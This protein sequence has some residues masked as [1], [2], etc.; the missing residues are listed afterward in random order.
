MGMRMGIRSHLLNGPSEYVKETEERF[1]LSVL[2]LV[3]GPVDMGLVASQRRSLRSV[4]EIPRLRLE[5]SHSPRSLWDT[6]ALARMQ[7]GANKATSEE[8]HCRALAF[9]CDSGVD[10]WELTGARAEAVIM[11]LHPRLGARSPLAALGVDGVQAVI[12]L[13]FAS[14]IPRGY[15]RA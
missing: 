7:F 12:G 8:F 15:P 9:A 5:G 4:E 1:A 6:R 10:L 2:G 14:S 3:Q 11:A 13:A